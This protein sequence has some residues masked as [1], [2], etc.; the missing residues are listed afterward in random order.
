MSRGSY[1]ERFAIRRRAEA[2]ASADTRTLTA[3]AKATA[4]PPKLHAKAE[5]CALRQIA[6][7]VG[8]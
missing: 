7:V 6:L 1:R 4:R 3:S 8:G 5:A 2:L